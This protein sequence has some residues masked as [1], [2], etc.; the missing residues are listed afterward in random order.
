MTDDLENNAEKIASN[1]SNGSLPEVQGKMVSVNQARMEEGG[2]DGG[3]NKRSVRNISTIDP[4]FPV[5]R[6]PGRNRSSIIRDKQS[7]DKQCRP[8]V[9]IN[10][11]KF[12]EII[13]NFN[14]LGLFCF[15]LWSS[16]L[17]A[18]ILNCDSYVVEIVGKPS[19]SRGVGIMG[20]LVSFAL[21]F[22]TNICYARWWEA[23]CAWGKLIA[24]TMHCAQQGESWIADEELSRRF[25]IMII[26]FA[27]ASKALLRGNSLNS[28]EE[29]GDALVSSGLIRQEELDF[30]NSQS[31]WQ[32]YY[33]I[34]AIREIMNVAWSKKD[35][36]TL[37]DPGAR[38]AAYRA[39][40]VSIENIA[41]CIGACIRVRATG[42]PISYNMFMKAS[43]VIFFAG[44]SLAW[45]SELRWFTPVIICAMYSLMELTIV[46]GDNMQAPFGSSLAGLPLQ[47]YCVIIENEISAIEE[48]HEFR[49]NLTTGTIVSTKGSPRRVSVVLLKANLNRR[50]ASSHSDKSWY[51]TKD[52]V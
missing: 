46:I 52:H 39:L 37:N 49:T 10:M 11:H 6:Q 29:E 30:M 8:P 14:F 40:E 13:S 23:R 26:V 18:I 20:T 35:G 1:P 51:S 44:A 36:C 22:R 41:E 31:G 45:S 19:T 15:A 4:V 32:P 25:I 16:A 17:T 2:S 27:Y 42:L 28:K 47:K 9:S 43:I 7:R 50:R 5:K 48:R 33:C 12:F 34:D 21:V 38:G 24:S 3:S